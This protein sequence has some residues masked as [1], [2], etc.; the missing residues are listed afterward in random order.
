MLNFCPGCGGSID[1]N[2]VG[3]QTVSCKHCGRLIGVATEGPREVVVDQT[4]ELIRGGTVSR[5]SMCRQVVQLKG[6]GQAKTF[7]P[8]FVTE[9]KMCPNSGKPAATP[10][11]MVAAAPAGLPSVAPFP[12]VK[13]PGGRDLSTYYAKELIRVVACA[14][15]QD[16]TIEELSLQY[17]DKADRVRTQIEA[18]R[19]ILGASFRMR[20][21][22]PA[23][24]KPHLAMWSNAEGCVIAKKHP[25]GGIQATTDVELIA[26]VG[27]IRENPAWF[28]E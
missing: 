6:S 3:G 1:Q 16:A 24:A 9:R 22:P 18:L 5:C 7:V 11:D 21:Y 4:E 13:T 15:G 26:M 19:E 8:H 28:F 2:Q 25:Q 10:A 14:K 23:L 12:A 27:D 20:D 17:L